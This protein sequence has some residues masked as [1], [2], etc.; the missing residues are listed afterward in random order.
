AEGLRETGLAQMAMAR[1]REVAPG[2]L[3]MPMEFTGIKPALRTFIATLFEENPY[4]FKPV[5]RG[6]YFTSALQEGVAMQPASE[7]VGR[8]FALGTASEDAPVPPA[9]ASYSLQGLFRRVI[10][11]AHGLGR[12]YSSRTRTRLRHA[13]FFGAVLLLGGALAAWSWSYTGNRQQV[14]DVA[15]DLDQAIAAQEGSVDLGSR[16]EALL[17]LQDRLEQL[18]R[19]RQDRPAGLGFGLYQGAALEEKLRQEYFNGMRQVML[20][21][22]T[23]RLEDYLAQ[24][25]AHRGALRTPPGAAADE[26]GDQA[27]STTGADAGGDLVRLYEEASPTDPQDA[28]N[29]LKTYL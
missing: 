17:V 29:A 15:A 24:V 2:L 19:Y 11:A 23:A 10:F 13:A 26:A 21:P 20:A 12:Q 22:V 25:V 1:G 14:A 28:Y 8:Q 7:R 9:D 18:E 27:G 5:F 3:T 6:F 4:Q 16:I